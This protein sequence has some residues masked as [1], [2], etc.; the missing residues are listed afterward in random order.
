MIEES[1][2][3]WIGALIFALSSLMFT[4]IENR[5]SSRE[6][7]FDSH[8]FVSFITTISY[9]IMAL[10]LATVTTENGDLILLYSNEEFV[11]IGGNNELPKHTVGNI[12]RVDSK[13]KSVT[14][15]LGGV[16]KTKKGDTFI[17]YGAGYE[18]WIL[19]VVRVYELCSEARI[20]ERDGKVLSSMPPVNSKALLQ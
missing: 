3:F 16:H 19:E 6:N 12:Y 10:G 5:N 8:V 18:E 9:C 13:N 17:V 14:I 11:S 4:F 15:D 2:V 1:V 7:K 20:I